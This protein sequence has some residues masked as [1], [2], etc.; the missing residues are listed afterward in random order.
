MKQQVRII[1]NVG[2]VIIL[3]LLTYVLTKDIL[4]NI[5]FFLTPHAFNNIPCLGF[6]YIYG[7]QIHCAEAGSGYTYLVYYSFYIV[8]IFLYGLITGLISAPKYKI[9][10]RT[11]LYSFFSILIIVL[12]VEFLNVIF[13]IRI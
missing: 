3:S 13:G 7:R 4:Y 5:A 8:T 6:Y 1:L 2:A 11:I 9:L 10:G 12:L